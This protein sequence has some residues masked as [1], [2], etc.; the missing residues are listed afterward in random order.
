MSDLEK[1]RILPL[2]PL[3]NSVLFPGLLMPL[4]VG[5]TSSLAAVEAAVATE[6]KEIIVV[7]QRDASADMPGASDLFTIGTRA[8]IRK[9]ARPGTRLRISDSTPAR[10]RRVST[11]LARSRALRSS[12]RRPLLAAT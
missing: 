3:K 4:S 7:A 1:I 6:D 2:L 11:P 8:A 9:V 5:R 12:Q 10:M